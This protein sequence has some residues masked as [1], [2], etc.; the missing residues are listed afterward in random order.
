MRIT[1][2]I[3][4]FLFGCS[5][6]ADE[7]VEATDAAL[8]PAPVGATVNVEFDGEN[9]L[10]SA[11]PVRFDEEGEITWIGSALAT[12]TVKDGLAAVKLPTRAPM[13]DR[14]SAHP[15]EP[16]YYYFFVQQLD[17]VGTPAEFLGVG[18]DRLVFFNGKDRKRSGWYVMTPGEGRATFSST[19]RIVQM[20]DGIR[21]SPGVNIVG[22]PGTVGSGPLMLGFEHDREHV[23][24]DGWVSEVT[25]QFYFHIEG[26]PPVGETLDDGSISASLRPSVFLDINEDGVWD[27]DEISVGAICAGS[28]SVSV[29]YLS[30][31]TQI[32]KAIMFARSHTVTGWHAYAMGEEGPRL[33]PAETE[34]VAHGNCAEAFSHVDFPED[35]NAN[36]GF[37]TGAP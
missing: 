6:S 34:F 29:S 5:Q 17:E 35:G 19:D 14:D 3:P 13:R 24:T 10:V 18:V 22:R 7:S 31:I 16:I 9:T 26:D 4:L 15:G 21:P 28:E 33:L 37:D 27:S 23:T 32:Q 30:P 12:G 11:Y 20:D 1:T 2:L 36:D 25:D 8:A